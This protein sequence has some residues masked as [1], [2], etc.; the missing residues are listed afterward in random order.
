[1]T[2]L[3][4]DYIYDCYTILTSYVFTNVDTTSSFRGIIKIKPFKILKIKSK[5]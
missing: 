1:M 4:S 2:E 5:C 3:E